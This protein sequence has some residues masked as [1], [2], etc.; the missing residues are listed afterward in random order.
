MGLS[1]SYELEQSQQIPRT[2]DGLCDDYRDALPRSII[3]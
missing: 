3:Q 2:V 1:L